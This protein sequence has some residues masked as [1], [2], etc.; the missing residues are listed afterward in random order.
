VDFSNFGQSVEPLLTVQ[1]QHS[2]VSCNDAGAYIIT[3]M[4][5]SHRNN[6]L[7]QVCWYFVGGDFANPLPNDMH[8]PTWLLTDQPPWVIRRGVYCSV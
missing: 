4:C 1:P 3:P 2:S 8:G 5:L 6:V 7:C